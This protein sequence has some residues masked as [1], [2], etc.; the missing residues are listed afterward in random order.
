MVMNGFD[1]NFDRANEVYAANTIG[2]AYMDQPI[3]VKRDELVRIYLVNVLEYDLDQLVPPA[4]QPLPLLPD[5]HAQSRRVHR[6]HDAL[7]GPARDPRVAL[8][9]PGKYMFHAHQSEFAELGWQGF[10]EVADGGAEPPNPQ[11]RSG[12]RRGCSGSSRWPDG[13]DRRDVRRARRPGLADRAGPPAEALVVDKLAAGSRTGPGG[14]AGSRCWPGSGA[15]G[16]HKEPMLE[17]TAES[18]TSEAAEAT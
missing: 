6:H 1:T 14:A 7:P 16:W 4:R 15:S 13:R 5:R 17:F 11:E 9:Y 18:A 2:F 8:P 3:K 10:F 12:A